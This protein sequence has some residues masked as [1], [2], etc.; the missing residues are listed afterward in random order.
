M[1]NLISALKS[2]IIRLARKEAKTATD[3]LRKPA[4]ATRST[5][6]SMKRRLA[7]LEKESRRLAALLE[8]LSS[9]CSLQPNNLQPSASKT[10]LTGRGMRKLRRRL[11]LSGVAFGK[12]VGVSRFAV[13]AWEANNGPLRLRPTTR[14]AILSIRHLGVREAKAR[15][16]ALAKK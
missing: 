5:M 1:P 4:G 7:A 14:A 12:L 9:S 3:P 2:E 6:A 16:Q 11:G 13:Y 10:R 8:K 15:V